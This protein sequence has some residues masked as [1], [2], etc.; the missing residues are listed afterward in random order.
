M[1]TTLRQAVPISEADR[2]RSISHFVLS[3]ALRRSARPYVPAACLSHPGERP[4][5]A[6]PPWKWSPLG[7]AQPVHR[8]PLHRLS[9][10][11]LVELVDEVPRGHVAPSRGLR[12]LGLGRWDDEGPD[13]HA[14]DAAPIASRVRHHNAKSPTCH[15]PRSSECDVK[16]LEFRTSRFASIDLTAD[17]LAGQRP[18]RVCQVPRRAFVCVGW[19]RPEQKDE[20]AMGLAG[21]SARQPAGKSR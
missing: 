9:V 3:A 20:A 4:I 14:A 8:R 5:R 13:S 10:S 2:E 7:L 18:L 17:V 1:C 15:T 16:P 21:R 19:A 6:R 12:T 11:P